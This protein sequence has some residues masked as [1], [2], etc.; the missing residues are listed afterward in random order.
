MAKTQF[1]TNQVS[2]FNSSWYLG[3]YSDVGNAFDDYTR[4]STPNYGL[5]VR[6]TP[7]LE[8][9]WRTTVQ[10]PAYGKYPAESRYSW[11]EKHWN[12]HGQGEGRAMAYDLGDD[13][14]IMSKDLANDQSAENA[15]GAYHFDTSGRNEGR[16]GTRDAWFH[17]P[18]ET[19]KRDDD[20]AAALQLADDVRAEDDRLF[21]KGLDDDNKIFLQG[22]RDDEKIEGEK[23]RIETARLAEEDRL[24]QLRM[25]DVQKVAMQKA[26]ARAE[27][28]RLAS[29]RGGGSQ[30]LSASGTAA[31]KGKGLTSSENKRGKGRGTRQ[32]R[33][34]Y[35]T[36]NLSIAATG[37]GNQQS[38]LNL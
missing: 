3:E 14:Y 1:K 18:G 9:T 29:S 8:N 32:F 21:L 26:A 33:R 34:P 15:Y 19:K 6:G 16:Y 22:I 5:Y 35:G 12:K 36:S 25:A 27:A 24:F 10:E 28:G 11:G 13:F 17:S 37:K 7:D 4:N 2:D 38:T 31:F 30:T 23:S 20:T